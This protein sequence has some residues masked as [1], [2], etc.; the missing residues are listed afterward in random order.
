MIIWCFTVPS[1]PFLFSVFFFDVSPPIIYDFSHMI[2]TVC[3]IGLELE[4]VAPLISISIRWL[5]KIDEEEKSMFG[6]RVFLAGVCKMEIG[7]HVLKR[8]SNS[9][10]RPKPD[11]LM[12]ARWF[13]HC[14]YFSL[15]RHRIAEAAPNCFSL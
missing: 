15:R 3:W 8:L 12:L 4:V 10:M 6:H 1:A 13:H 14:W 2:T 5:I 9:L 11:Q 7:K